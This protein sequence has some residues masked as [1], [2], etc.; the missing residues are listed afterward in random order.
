[1]YASINNNEQASPKS[2]F[3][4]LSGTRHLIKVTCPIQ[5]VTCHSWCVQLSQNTDICFV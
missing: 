1:M 3:S 2:F 4:H 5:K